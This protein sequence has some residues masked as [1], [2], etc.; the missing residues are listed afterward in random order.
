MLISL[1]EYSPTMG[2]PRVSREAEIHLFM[3]QN[4]KNQARSACWK[5]PQGL[6]RF[7]GQR[8]PA[9][10]GV[11]R[12]GLGWLTGT[13]AQQESGCPAADALG[14]QSISAADAGR[15]LQTP[16]GKSE[17]PAQQLPQ[18]QGELK[19]AT[20]FLQP[21]QPLCSAEKEGAK[22]NRFLFDKRIFDTLKW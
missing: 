17:S 1:N 2:I 10:T 6:E 15:D 14:A 9:S 12:A 16:P 20:S 13:G 21:E 7:S 8:P 4:S 11:Q 5:Q 18:Q 22:A 3:R 19:P